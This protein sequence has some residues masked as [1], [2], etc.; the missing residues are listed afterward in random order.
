M[1]S[2]SLLDKFCPD[3]FSFKDHEG[4]FLS[5]C[6]REAIVM[7]IPIVFYFILGSF[8][9]ASLWDV[10]LWNRWYIHDF[11]FNMR[12]SLVYK[13][14]WI[15][16]FLSLVSIIILLQFSFLL[17]IIDS[18][19]VS[20][21]LT[22]IQYLV[23]FAKTIIW[24]IALINFIFET[25][26]NLKSWIITKAFYVIYF[27][28]TLIQEIFYIQHLFYDSILNAYD[29]RATAFQIILMIN[30]LLICMEILGFCVPN[31]SQYKD[32][33]VENKIK[34]KPKVGV[35]LR[36]ID[37]VELFY[38]G[39]YFLLPGL[40]FGIGQGVSN[41][42][43]AENAGKVIDAQ[44]IEEVKS[45][46][47]PYLYLIPIMAISTI[48]QMSF[49]GLGGE[50]ILM[51][52]RN[53]LLGSFGK[54]DISFF[55]RM[56]IGYLI[57]RITTDCDIIGVGLT[58]HISALVPPAVSVVTGFVI[59]MKNSMT[60]AVLLISFLLT[61]FIVTVLRSRLIT[62]RYAATYSDK[63]AFATRKATEVIQGIDVVKTFGKESQELQGYKKFTSSQRITGLTK[64]VLES[65]FEAA[66]GALNKSIIALGVFFG[67]TLVF[68]NQI[69]RTE[70]NSFLLVGITTIND[71]YACVKVLPELYNISA[72]T[73]RVFTL[74]KMKPK[75]DMDKGEIIPPEEF[76][77]KIEFE[78]ITFAY[79]SLNP[80]EESA[81][82]INGL[83]LTINAG[84]SIAFCGSS[85]SG[86]S[87]MLA[88]A[89]RFF[90]VNEGRVLVDGRDIKSL[91]LR[92]WLEQLGI[93]AQQSLL[94]QGSIEENI[95]YSCKTKQQ[96]ED[97]EAFESAIELADARPVIESHEEGIK[98]NVG[99]RGDALSG[100]QKQRVSIARM[101]RKQ[102]KVL[103]L[104]EVTSALDPES[105][106]IA[107]RGLRRLAKGKTT[108]CVAHRL[109]T[110]TFCDKI[111]CMKKGRIVEQ[112]SHD[113][114]V[115]IEGG[116]YR[117]LFEKQQSINQEAAGTDKSLGEDIKQD[118]SIL[119]DT[120][121]AYGF[122]NQNEIKNK[123]EQIKKK[124]QQ[125]PL[126]QTSIEIRQVI[127]NEERTYSKLKSDETPLLQG[128][129]VLDENDIYDDF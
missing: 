26:R 43:I 56:G 65:L 89:M 33:V 114:L 71:F 8:R 96:W 98:F 15:V 44:S 116:Y 2:K 20:K 4:F 115:K 16:K 1:S 67:A 120:I 113:E 64:E 22:N 12:I 13:F 21:E 119:L 54:Q 5:T 10:P 108:L 3:G 107:M 66:E 38:M 112:G 40:I 127:E 118:V 87:T 63:R 123:V 41:Q 88:L 81:P 83:S 109:H 80:H 39:W 104:D 106:E 91:K 126:E 68:N 48:F 37:V 19:F 90:D 97:E 45:L 79:P 95:K 46:C 6:V 23:D 50:T 99:A 28:A 62:Q 57:S 129:S 35:N 51:K 72:P 73:E 124:F 47:S 49:L 7:I 93:V 61:C 111:V 58:V 24:I 110:I 78:N 82:V 30:L 17:S 69:E 52:M 76:K 11:F 27:T 77:G 100:G 36:L 75:T 42:V 25:R 14:G 122:F 86:K 31:L 121:E 18:V 34:K 60:L 74:M 70:L 84:E 32:E 53:K 29:I 55:Q 85:G 125:K 128:T 9:F 92:W 94:F 105:E 103:F 59:L 102:P 101:A 117:D